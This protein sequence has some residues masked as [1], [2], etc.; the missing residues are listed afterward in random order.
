MAALHV[1]AV[2]MRPTAL[3]EVTHPTLCSLAD[4]SRAV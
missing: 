1:R 4:G 3:K 2:P